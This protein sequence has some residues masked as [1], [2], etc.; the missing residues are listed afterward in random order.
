L[1]KI[2]HKRLVAGKRSVF[3]CRMLTALAHLRRG[4]PAGKPRRCLASV[5]APKRYGSIAEGA[6]TGRRGCIVLNA[7]GGHVRCFLL[8]LQNDAR[9][10]VMFRVAESD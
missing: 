4:G 3:Q 7:P 6:N 1:P 5:T 10:G 9:D 8:C 2:F